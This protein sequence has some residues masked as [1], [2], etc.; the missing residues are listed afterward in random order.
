M[1]CRC[2]VGTLAE[3]E[4]LHEGGARSLWLRSPATDG[5]RS[6][7]TLDG[8]VLRWYY[9]EGKRA[10]TT[11][12]GLVEKADFVRS[13]A[14]TR[15]ELRALPVAKLRAVLRQRGI[16]AEGLV[17]KADFVEAIARGHEAD[18]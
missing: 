10:G 18:E 8:A 4:C 6:Y 7:Y 16:A 11:S 2:V 13:L 1:P 12:E 9:I 17:E 3:G 5:A 14:C 15:A